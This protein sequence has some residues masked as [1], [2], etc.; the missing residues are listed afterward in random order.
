MVDASMSWT[1]ALVERPST[2]GYF[3]WGVSK[4]SKVHPQFSEPQ[5]HEVA[6]PNFIVFLVKSQ[7]ALVFHKTILIKHRIIIEFPPNCVPVFHRF[8][9]EIMFNPHGLKATV[10]RTCQDHV[11]PPRLLFPVIRALATVIPDP[12]GLIRLNLCPME[13]DVNYIVLPH[14]KWEKWYVYSG[15]FFLPLVIKR[16]YSTR[17]SPVFI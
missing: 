4:V 16:Y 3:F 13:N 2:P 17:K 11:I 1:M 7:Y 15:D 6:Y 12:W 9:T 10:R 14:E 8:P 5:A